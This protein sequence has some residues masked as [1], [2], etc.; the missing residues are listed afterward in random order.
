M[1]AVDV[2]GGGVARADVPVATVPVA[3]VPVA[4]LPGATV[5]VAT[6]PAAYAAPEVMWC[7]RRRWRWVLGATEL[8]WRVDAAWLTHRHRVPSAG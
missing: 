2:A 4:E 1:E 5:P 6:V 3:T 7:S 8:A